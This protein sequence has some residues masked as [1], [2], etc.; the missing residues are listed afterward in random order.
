MSENK[1]SAKQKKKDKNVISSQIKRKKKKHAK[2]GIISCVF[3]GS[4]LLFLGMAVAIA[5]YGLKQVTFLLGGLGAS[6]VVLT[7]MGIKASMRGRKEKDR[8]YLTCNI[9]LV[10]NILLLIGLV[11]IYIR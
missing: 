4:A 3:A 8:R 7:L 11:I 6:A 10:L 5:F 1:K 2:M 9:G